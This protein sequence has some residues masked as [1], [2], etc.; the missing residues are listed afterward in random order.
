MRRFLSHKIYIFPNICLSHHVVEYSD[1]KH[2]VACYPFNKE[3]ENTSFY[4]GVLY[5]LPQLMDIQQI[6]ET[7]I[8]GRASSSEIMWDDVEYEVYDEDRKKLI[9]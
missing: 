2:I 7:E 1:E 8:T 6:N 3:A 4:N 5:F 9:L